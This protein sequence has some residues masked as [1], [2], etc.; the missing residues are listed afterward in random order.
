MTSTVSFSL[1][2]AACAGM[3]WLVL[4]SVGL[5][6]SY[7][8]GIVP[9]FEARRL[10]RIWDP[11]LAEISSRTGY[12][13]KFVGSPRIPE[14]EAAF[15]EGEF[16]FAYMNPYH[17]TQAR[18]A[19]G[20]LPLVRD[21]ARQLYGVLVVRQDSP[22][23][24]PADLAG[25]V[26]AFPAPNALGASLMIRADLASR[27]EINFTPSYVSTHGSAYLNV[28]LGQAAAAGG[29]MAT[30]DA[31]KPE[32]RDQLRVLYETNRVAPHPLVAHPR[33][34]VEVRQSVTQALLD[35]ARTEEG[36]NLLEQIPIKIPI[37]ARPDDYTPLET[38]GLDAFVVE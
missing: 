7:T 27:H 19:Q 22:Y 4:A 18:H 36:R 37:K 32:I 1:L 15:L 30:F 10:T 38:M 34:P 16:D 29:V 12:E 31:Q 23:Q 3:L 33:V 8:I 17:Y 28:V 9:Q 6:Q 21:G 11:I 25:Q 13:L 20:Y 26:I 24:T 35:L 14:F 2:R 5:A